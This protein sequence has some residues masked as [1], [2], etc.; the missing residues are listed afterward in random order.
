MN[1]NTRSRVILV[2]YIREL[3]SRAQETPLTMM[4]VAF[5]PLETMIYILTLTQMS[6]LAQRELNYLISII[7]HR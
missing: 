3:S 2:G 6:G 4:G 7:I 5:K 1:D